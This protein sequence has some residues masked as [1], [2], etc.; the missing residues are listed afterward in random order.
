MITKYFCP[1]FGSPYDCTAHIDR[2]FW[3]VED[4]K[5]VPLYSADMPKMPMLPPIPSSLFQGGS[6]PLPSAPTAPTPD[7]P[8]GSVT[9]P[10]PGQYWSPLPPGTPGSSTP[11]APAAPAAP[12]AGGYPMPYPMSPYAGYGKPMSCE[13]KAAPM[14]C[15]GQNSE[16]DICTWNIITMKCKGC[17]GNDPKCRCTR[18]PTQDICVA[19]ILC[20]WS[21]KKNGCTSVIEARK[22]N[23]AFLPPVPPGLVPAGYTPPPADA[24]DATNTTAA[25]AMPAGAP[26]LADGADP[27]SAGNATSSGITLASPHLL[28]KTSPAYSSSVD[29]RIICIIPFAILLGAFTGVIASDYVSKKSETLEPVP[30]YTTMEETRQV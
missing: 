5:C 6:V 30:M 22:D 2:C 18:H 11:P 28:K 7:A 8:Y 26:G 12:T 27:G 10:S 1:Q 29:Y 24:A 13:A 23:V 19:Q 16:G 3:E 21:M 25:P 9:I 14:L 15:T 20:D 17:K 4:R